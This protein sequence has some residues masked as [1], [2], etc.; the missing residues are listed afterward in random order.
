MCC[1][2]R[3]PKQIYGV[4]WWANSFSKIVSSHDVSTLFVLNP[5]NSCNYATNISILAINQQPCQLEVRYSQSVMAAAGADQPANNQLCQTLTPL[6]HQ[7]A[8]V[9][10]WLQCWH[11]T[12]ESTVQQKLTNS[13]ALPADGPSELLKNNNLWA[14]KMPIKSNWISFLHDLFHRL[15][16]SHINLN[17]MILVACA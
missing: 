15:S 13:P 12:S 3:L 1:L 6:T 10:A 8:D 17:V 9:P 16:R 2:T 11:L 5:A 7:Q 4:I 14:L